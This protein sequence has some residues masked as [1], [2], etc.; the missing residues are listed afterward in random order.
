MANFTRQ[1][2]EAAFMKLL[3]SKPLNKISVRDIVE[4]CGINR[5]SFYYHFRDIPSLLGEIITTNTDRL[6][7][8]YPSISSLDECFEVAFRFAEKNRN[9]VMHI[10]YSVSR[11]LFESGAMKLCEYAVTSYIDTAFPEHQMEPDDRQALIRFLKCQL[12]GM[13]IDWISDGMQEE[14]Y[15][16]LQRMMRLCQGLPELLLKR[17][18]GESEH[19]I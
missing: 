17:C 11:D 5:N 15:Q 14:R 8:E 7:E 13:C 19:S 18:R 16:E 10:Y 3:N 2:I 1:A 6:I 4:E 9:A 12:F